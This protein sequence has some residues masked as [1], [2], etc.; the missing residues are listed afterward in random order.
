MMQHY[1][2]I[3]EHTQHLNYCGNTTNIWK[4]L[5][6]QVMHLLAAFGRAGWFGIS[7]QTFATY[8]R[9]SSEAHL[10]IIF[11]PPIFNPCLETTRG[12]LESGNLAQ[13]V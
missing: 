1:M 5:L 9:H 12:L 2:E 3:Q 4:C 13:N 10:Q 7:S 6:A 11:F 8:M